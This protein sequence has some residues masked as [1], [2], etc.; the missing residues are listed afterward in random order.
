MKIPSWWQ[1]EVS[2]LESD[3]NIGIQKSF[4]VIHITDTHLTFTDEETC[5]EIF[6]MVNLRRRMFSKNIENLKIAKE[7]AKKYNAPIVHTGDIIDFVTKENLDYA[8]Q[9]I[10]ENQVIF[11]VGNHEFLYNFSAVQ[12]TEKHKLSIFKTI[13][14]ELSI[15]LNFSS[16]IINGVNFVA[17]DN[18]FYQFNAQQLMELKKEVEKGFPIVLC[19]HNPLYEESFFEYKYNL[20]GE[21]CAALVG[22]PK[23]K[24]KLYSKVH[25]EM[26]KPNTA[27]M[28]FIEYIEKEKQIKAVFCGHTH[29]DYQS[30][31]T[32]GIQQIATG[33]N[34]IRVI[35][36][37]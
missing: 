5:K 36:I 9:Y 1:T 2:I 24:L 29:V 31:L 34:T 27:T 11:A 6:E 3:L 10:R 7:L 4:K 26:Q 22:V 13:E 15:P 28:D 25:A 20:W 32:C 16:R 14:N 30:V 17:L 35:T 8:R 12:S 19:M 33:I 18:G 21:R 23:D 37:R